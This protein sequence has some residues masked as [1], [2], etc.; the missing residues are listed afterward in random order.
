[1][2]PRLRKWNCWANSELEVGDWKLEIGGVDS[3]IQPLI[4]NLQPLTKRQPP[5]FQAHKMLLANHQM[6]EHLHIQEFP[7]LDK[8]A[9]HHH[10]VRAGGRVPA[11]MVVDHD[12]RAGVAPD[13][14]FEQLP[15]V[16]LRRIDRATLDFHHFQL[17]IAPVEQQHAQMFLFQGAHLILHKVRCTKASAFLLNN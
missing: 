14:G 10:V 9:R 4:S 1:M 12:Q 6:I 11:G 5:L 13:G 8:C 2:P 17:V 3:T 7:G 15:H 16:H